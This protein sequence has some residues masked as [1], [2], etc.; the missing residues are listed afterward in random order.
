MR[1]AEAILSV[2]F[3]ALALC[4]CSGKV[5]LPTKTDQ[6][7]ALAQLTVAPA[8]AEAPPAGSDLT[9]N[10]QGSLDGMTYK[11]NNA[12]TETSEPLTSAVL[13]TYEIGLG[14]DGAV[15]LTFASVSDE[16]TSDAVQS[17]RTQSDQDREAVIGSMIAARDGT[18]NNAV[19]ERSPAPPS[20][21]R[22]MWSYAGTTK[23][24]VPVSVHGYEFVGGAQLYE[25]A[26][27]SS[28]EEA[29]AAFESTWKSLVNQLKFPDIE[30]IETPVI[31]VS[32][33]KP[34]ST[35]TPAPTYNREAAR[36]Q[37]EW[38]TGYWEGRDWDGDLLS[39]EVHFETLAGDFDTFSIYGH[40]EGSSGDYSFYGKGAVQDGYVSYS[41]TL[42]DMD[43][44]DYDMS[45]RLTPDGASSMRCS[46]VQNGQNIGTVTMQ[47]L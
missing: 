34:K 28:S 45:G 1:T 35:P 23:D 27:T 32:T 36:A 6:D 43:G 20:G 11:Y 47:R 19:S 39:L 9:L 15:T 31:P 26:V 38:Y 21:T 3:L 4:G 2:F 13:R 24:E 42:T 33:P 29:F 7:R 10:A 41:G 12:W 18:L 16:S 14:A 40:W 37:N 44:K 30:P 17:L 46:V 8:T 25:V 5:L 22:A